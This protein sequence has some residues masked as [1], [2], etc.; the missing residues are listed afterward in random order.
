M[1][2]VPFHIASHKYV[3]SHSKHILNVNRHI[4]DLLCLYWHNSD[5]RQRILDILI[6]YDYTIITMYNINYCP[7]FKSRSHSYICQMIGTFKVLARRDHLYRNNP[8]IALLYIRLCA[9]E[10][11]ASYKKIYIYLMI[12]ITCHRVWENR[13]L[14]HNIYHATYY[15]VLVI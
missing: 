10:K 15:C 1:Q 4:C 6:I 14:Y 8:P 5:F 3:C 9:W 7:F 2:V 12:L 11:V 13:L